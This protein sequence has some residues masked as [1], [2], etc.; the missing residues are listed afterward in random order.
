WALGLWCV[1]AGAIVTLAVLDAKRRTRWRI[2]LAEQEMLR[3]ASVTD[4]LT[5]LHNRRF[6]ATFLQH[7][8]PK[9][10]RSHRGERSRAEDLLIVVLDV[11]HLKLLNDVHG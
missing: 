7:E 4:P 2:A 10:L 1:L 3:R 6:L 5:G 9:A 8:V 11:D